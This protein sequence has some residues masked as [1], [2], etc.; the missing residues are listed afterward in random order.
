ML[1]A[2]R[3]LVGDAVLALGEDEVRGRGGGVGEAVDEPVG[4]DALE[5]LQ[6][7][8]FE[9]GVIDGKVFVG[10]VRVQKTEQSVNRHAGRRRAAICQ[11]CHGVRLRGPRWFRGMSPGK[12]NLL[13][14]DAFNGPIR[15]GQGI[16]HEL[17]HLL[18]G[19]RTRC[20]NA[21]RVYPISPR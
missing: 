15:F 20:K 9:V 6:G 8:L 1:R 4:K 19:R 17:R 12:C 16:Q 3:T 13:G 2:P 10:N 11:V 18:N 7:R 5:E 14:R 21:V